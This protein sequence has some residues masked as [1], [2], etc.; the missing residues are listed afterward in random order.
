VPYSHRN[1]NNN[2]N[3]NNLEDRGKEI[4]LLEWISIANC[5]CNDNIPSDSIARK[6][7]SFLLIQE[8][9]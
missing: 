1:N 8:V 4:I 9:A 2:N 6:L 5:G 7:C 3:N